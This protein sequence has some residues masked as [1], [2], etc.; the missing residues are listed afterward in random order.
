ML[1]MVLLLGAGSMTGKPYI[2]EFGMPLKDFI[3]AD[4]PTLL[5]ICDFQ[6]KQKKNFSKK[7][8]KKFRGFNIKRRP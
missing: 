6:M 1:I 5:E 2:E 8:S 4:C 3:H 7:N